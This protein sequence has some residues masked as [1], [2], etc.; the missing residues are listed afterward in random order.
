MW[1]GF[2]ANAENL[3][4]YFLVGKQ[5]VLSNKQTLSCST[6]QSTPM[7][8]KCNLT[9]HYVK[10]ATKTAGQRLKCKDNL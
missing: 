9:E 6:G 3:P 2:E 1:S 5:N 8:A 10:D 4:Q 7:G